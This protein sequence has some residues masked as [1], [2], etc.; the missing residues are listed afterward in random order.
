MQ[1][2][3]GEREPRAQSEGD[4]WRADHGHLATKVVFVSMV[5]YGGTLAMK[6]GEDDAADDGTEDE[7]PRRE[8]SSQADVSSGRQAFS[9][10]AISDHPVDRPQYRALR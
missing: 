10:V 1:E 5:S 9:W 4:N 7:R 6:K 8:A 3:V 2:E